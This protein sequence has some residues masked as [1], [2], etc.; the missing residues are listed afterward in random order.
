M[1]NKLSLSGNSFFNN[2]N[3]QQKSTTNND[4]LDRFLSEL[5]ISFRRCNFIKVL[6]DIAMKEDNFQDNE[7]YWKLYDINLNALHRLIN[8]TNHKVS[9]G[10]STNK[11]KMLNILLIKYEDTLDKWSGELNEVMR[12]N[13]N[14]TNV[15][16]NNPNTNVKS[17]NKQH[18]H[19]NQEQSNYNTISGNFN[20]KNLKNI[21]NT[22]NTNNNTN[23]LINQYQQELLTKHILHEVYNQALYA[24][25]NNYIQKSLAYL[26][27]GI[28]LITHCVH[29]TSDPDTLSAAQ[30]VY[31]FMSSLFI[32]N[33]DYY[34]AVDL[35]SSSLKFAWYEL[36][37]RS[38]NNPELNLSEYSKLELNHIEQMFTN[39]VLGFYQRGVCF[40]NLGDKYKAIEAYKQSRWFSI[41]YLKERNPAL[42]QFMVDV[43]KNLYLSIYKKKELNNNNNNDKL[44]SKNKR[45]LF[46]PFCIF[47]DIQQDNDS[48][49]SKNEKYNNIIKRIEKMKFINLENP[50]TNYFQVN[51]TDEGTPRDVIMSTYRIINTLT[52]K[53]FK[54]FV[55]EID[56]L[57]MFKYNKMFQE[58]LRRKIAIDNLGIKYTKKN[59]RNLNG[60]N[61]SSPNKKNSNLNN[62]NN[63]SNTKSRKNN[64]TRNNFS[65]N[66]YNYNLSGYYESDE[67]LKPKFNYTKSPSPIK[68]RKSKNQNQTQT[69]IVNKD[70]KDVKDNMD[71]E[72]LDYNKLLVSEDNTN[73][74]SNKSMNKSIL[75]NKKDENNVKDIDKNKEILTIH[76]QSQTN[77]HTL[78]SNSKDFNNK[79]N[80]NNN[81]DRLNSTNTS[82]K[83]LEKI[84]VNSNKKNNTNTITKS[85]TSTINNNI[86]NNNNTSHRGN[87]HRNNINTNTNTNTN[88]KN[89]K[90]KPKIS[91]NTISP[92][93]SISHRG[94]R[95]IKIKLSKNN[96]L[97]T[98][99]PIHTHNPINTPINNPEKENTSN[100]NTINI[101]T[102][103]HS[104]SPS[105]TY[106]PPKEKKS[107][108]ISNIQNYNNS[109]NH[110]ISKFYNYNANPHFEKLLFNSSVFNK[111]YKDKIG[112]IEKFEIKE[113]LFQKKLLKSK[114]D[115]KINV[116]NVD[117]GKIGKHTESFFHKVLV[118]NDQ[119]NAVNNSNNTNNNF[120]MMSSKMLNGLENKAAKS[121]SIKNF[122]DYCKYVK[123]KEK[124]NK[125]R[126]EFM[127]VA[128]NININKNNGIGG[129]MNSSNMNNNQKNYE[130]KNITTITKE[131]NKM[132]STIQNEIEFMEKI[133]CKKMKS[134]GFF[135][136]L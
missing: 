43:E 52:S 119:N 51:N 125:L 62:P 42:A 29:K 85:N 72:S 86:I 69:Q 132:I 82:R 8:K 68:K 98:N 34:H 14:N 96:S 95:K 45:K 83:L 122:N 113:M 73:N 23:S 56:N 107:S 116:N 31:L 106:K 94:G 131:N 117:T 118:S 104:S 84:I 70:N 88:N 61:N 47:S 99:N 75:K 97:L 27:V 38:Y 124:S 55:S 54:E 134:K 79:N 20:T 39:I 130:E 71:L 65:I 17:P 77:N 41:N 24:K 63:T 81:N 126:D 120:N 13:M 36:S 35:Q 103:N 16:T 50:N 40:E 105:P 74:L 18:L 121:L 46:Q 58:K 93:S 3:T 90:P 123:S 115:E 108:N 100:L 87:I 7:H 48:S 9:A 32:S 76:I 133:E 66:N 25:N 15:N 37:A 64:K 128:T 101:T 135:T 111:N 129:N 28:R 114:K 2:S 26:S 12:T 112:Y 102:L 6:D 5:T 110:I 89:T 49:L 59:V 33:H 19:Y 67:D 78:N 22:N 44:N 136:A 11:A 60:L 30:K 10:Q 127:N 109:N 92:C 4:Q 91:F 1:N 57:Q 53:F 21:I 80:Y